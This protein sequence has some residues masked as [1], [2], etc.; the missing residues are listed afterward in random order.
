MHLKSIN[1]FVDF[2]MFTT[3]LYKL[4]C[5]ISLIQIPLPDPFSGSSILYKLFSSDLKDNHA[6]NKRTANSQHIQYSTS[7]IHKLG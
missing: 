2:W 5:L 3:N 6:V 7:T 4:I 1:I